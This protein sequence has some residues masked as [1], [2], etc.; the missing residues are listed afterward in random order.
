ML[1]FYLEAGQSVNDAMDAH[2]F[3]HLMKK[4]YDE[5]TNENLIGLF[6]DYFTLHLETRTLRRID[7]TTVVHGD[8]SKANEPF[9]PSSLNWR[10][11][12]VV[13]N[14]IRN[15]HYTIQDDL[16][17]REAKSAFQNGLCL[18]GRFV[19]RP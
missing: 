10:R 3:L 1:A 18:R 11:E 19:R 16:D 5:N 13:R 12:R 7:M 9:L 17:L 14:L 6:G 2:K 4:L 8:T 15:G